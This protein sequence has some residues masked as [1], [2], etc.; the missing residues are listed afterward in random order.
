MIDST[1]LLKMPER[2][3]WLCSFAIVA[4]L[5]MIGLGIF[6]PI[7]ETNDDTAMMGIVSGITYGHPS[8]HIVFS[9]V[10]IGKTLAALYEL[11]PSI[12]WYGVYLYIFQALAAFLIIRSLLW[13]LSPVSVYDLLL[14]LI[15]VIACI[16]IVIYLQFTSTAILM[17]VA[18]C[19]LHC[20]T[21]SKAS[22]RY[23]WIFH[24]LAGLLLGVAFMIRTTSAYVAVLIA[25]PILVISIRRDRTVFLRTGLFIIIAIVV[26]I[27]TETTQRS[28]YQSHHDW[29]KYFTYNAVRGALHGYP[30]LIS[31]DE[32]PSLYKSIGWSAN[33]RDMFR[34][35]FFTDPLRY[36]YA[37]LQKIVADMPPLKKTTM[38]SF[39]A[40]TSIISQWPLQVCLVLAVAICQTFMMCGRR[41]YFSF[42]YLLYVFLILM[43]FTMFAR[44]PNRVAMP[45]LIC[46]LL[47]IVFWGSSSIKKNIQVSGRINVVMLLL[48]F[49]SGTILFKLSDESS[50]NIR[51]QIALQSRIEELRK[52]GPHAVFVLWS[53][54]M[55]LHSMNPL[56]IP[57]NDLRSLNFVGLGWRTHSPEFNYHLAKLCLSD[58]YK[59]I[60]FKQNVYLI[61]GQSRVPYY[62]QYL[63]EHYG[64]SGTLRTVGYLYGCSARIYNGFVIRS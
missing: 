6:T 3:P 19:I 31:F 2:H 12:P 51:R 13:A 50:M 52:L 1:A 11:G 20:A 47:C 36:S 25:L 55:E 54:D 42:A 18:A 32:K 24:I 60:A 48:V 29:Q 15:S 26:A 58:L 17:G 59:D 45:V 21:L 46:V 44:L 61:S 41:R 22:L 62:E 4:A 64:L 28:F 33:D 10:L 35:W 40:I 53:G 56:R 63:K 37:N 38:G 49:F 57:H 5:Y 7:F 27:G 14:L 23:H 8:P 39:D 43:Y 9:N 30:K 16:P 34:L